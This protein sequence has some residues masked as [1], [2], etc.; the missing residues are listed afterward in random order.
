MDS[1]ALLAQWRAFL[2]SPTSKIEAIVQEFLE[3]NPS[4][5]P[6][7]HTLDT[8]S[9]WSPWPG[10][11]ISQPPLP[12]LSTKY[13]D[14]MWIAADSACLYPILIEIE[15]PWKKW[16]HAD[17]LVQ[18][19]ELTAPLSQVAHW[20]A[21]F[22]TGRNQ[23][24]FLDDYRIPRELQDHAFQPRYVIIHGRRS[25]ASKSPAA[26]KFRAS[27]ASS[28]DV[29]L[30]TFDRLVPDPRA[31][32]YFTVAVDEHGFMLHPNSPPV[33]PK[34]LDDRALREVRGLIGAELEPT[35][36]AFVPPP[37]QRQYESNGRP[38][39]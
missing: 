1:E 22:E 14:F 34:T 30:M 10:A 37:R 8:N 32:D 6:G 28:S 2:D 27:L 35:A 5:L 26:I 12:G 17:K 21:W 39:Y 24:A 16:Y 7:S 13:P 36:E 9:G 23:A 25:E 38:D 33:D 29:R 15:T 19:S 3:R 11:V 31:A 18:H 4:L 20:R